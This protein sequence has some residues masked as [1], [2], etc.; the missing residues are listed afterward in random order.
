[1]TKTT[2]NSEQPKDDNL[3]GREQQLIRKV[4]AMKVETSVLQIDMDNRLKEFRRSVLNIMLELDEWAENKI[5]DEEQ[6]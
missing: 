1:M 2:T 3:G 6:R 4:K 5:N